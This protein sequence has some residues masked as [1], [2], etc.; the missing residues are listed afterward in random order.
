MTTFSLVQKDG[1]R[2]LVNG[3]MTAGRCYVFP[4]G[5]EKPLCT[6]NEYEQDGEGHWEIKQ[7]DLRPIGP[8]EALELGRLLR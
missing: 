7:D 1:N 3:I 4:N 6:E 2:T 5:M 8:G